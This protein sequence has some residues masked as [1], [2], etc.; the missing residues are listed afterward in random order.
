MKKNLLN[1]DSLEMNVAI[2]QKIYLAIAVAIAT[3]AHE[4]NLVNAGLVK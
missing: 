4:K 3:V 2:S 1:D